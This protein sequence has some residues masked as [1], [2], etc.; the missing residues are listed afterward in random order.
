MIVVAT[1]TIEIT[2]ARERIAGLERRA[3]T[4]TR[5]RLWDWLRRKQ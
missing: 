5:R 2:Q 1:D 3:P 4:A